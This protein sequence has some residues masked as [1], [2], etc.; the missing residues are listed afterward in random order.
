MLR[1]WLDRLERGDSTARFGID[2]N[3]DLLVRE[4][5]QVVERRDFIAANAAPA[6]FD[7]ENGAPRL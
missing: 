2:G 7:P 1:R 4:G 3:A 6:W 5:T